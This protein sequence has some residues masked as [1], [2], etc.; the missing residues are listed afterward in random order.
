MRPT[1]FVCSS[2]CYVLL[3]TCWWINKLSLCGESNV[4]TNKPVAC[5]SPPLW[6]ECQWWLTPTVWALPLHIPFYS[7]ALPSRIPYTLPVFISSSLCLHYLHPSISCHSFSVGLALFYVRHTWALASVWKWSS[8]AFKHSALRALGKLDE[9][10]M[11]VSG[12]GR[13]TAEW[14]G[15]VAGGGGLSMWRARANIN[16]LCK[17]AAQT[18]WQAG[19]TPERSWIKSMKALASLTLDLQPRSVHR[20]VPVMHTNN[21]GG[22]GRTVTSQHTLFSSSSVRLENKSSS[23]TLECK[24]C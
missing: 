19:I 21:S 14:R 2:K 16:S 15:V 20:S 23:L 17:S 13:R 3:A 18:N 7:H 10:R 24:L 5:S 12:G 22:A 9:R 11:R 1:E 8:F 4:T 6:Q